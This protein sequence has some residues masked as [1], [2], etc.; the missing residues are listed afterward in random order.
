M[1]E[2]HLRL[3]GQPI[4]ITNIQAFVQ[5]YSGRSHYR[6]H[7]KRLGGIGNREWCRADMKEKGVEDGE[8]EELGNG[9]RNVPFMNFSS[10]LRFLV[11]ASHNLFMS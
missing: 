4:K 9:G 10:I 7:R 8:A 1:S 6:F 5:H 3:Q 2:D 11:I